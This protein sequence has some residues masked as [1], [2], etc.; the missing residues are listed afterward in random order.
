[1]HWISSGILTDLFNNVILF[2]VL[3]LLLFPIIPLFPWSIHFAAILQPAKLNKYLS[4]W[5]FSSI[6]TKFG[7]HFFWATN[8]R[9]LMN[10]G[11]KNTMMGPGAIS[12]CYG[13]GR[14]WQELYKSG[15]HEQNVCSLN[16]FV[17]SF[18]Y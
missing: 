10:F 7:V 6:N 8:Y 13:G 4:T 15:M 5:N 2:K 12:F 14:E 1:V 17:C 3:F 18:F 9:F 11:H 16:V